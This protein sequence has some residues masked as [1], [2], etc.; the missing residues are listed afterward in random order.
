M[1]SATTKALTAVSTALSETA[2]VDLTTARELFEAAR[3]LGG[4]GHLTSAL[5]D[6]ASPVTARERLVAG[7][8]GGSLSSTTVALLTAAASQRW[9]SADDLV[10]GVEELGVRAAARADSADVEAELFEVSRVVAAHPELELALGSR[11]GQSADKGELVGAILGGRVSEGTALIVSSLVRQPGNRR[12]RQLLSRAMTIVSEERGRTVAT[13]FTAA[14]L[15]PDQ[16]ARLSAL[17]SARYGRDI[18]INEVI[19]SSVVGGVRIQVADDVIDA[20]I[21]ARLA[22]L[23]HRLAG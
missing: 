6:P 17:L 9:S 16:S 2:A 23:R 8:F 20:S 1:G 7:V 3:A 19:D 14:A 18:T 5:A 21:A 10:N 15:T 11:L 12:V 13:V 22:D 4:S